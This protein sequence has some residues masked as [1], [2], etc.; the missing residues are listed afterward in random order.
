MCAGGIGRLEAQAREAAETQ[1]RAAQ[2]GQAAVRQQ[3]QHVQH[4]CQL[5]DA[6]AALERELA[7]A[8]RA[9][10]EGAAAAARAQRASDASEA[11]AAAAHEVALSAAAQAT[12]ALHVAHMAEGWRSDRT[13]NGSG[14]DVQ[15]LRREVGEGFAGV[16]ETIASLRAELSAMGEGQ[17][18]VEQEAAVR[19]RVM[20]A[21]ALDGGPI[22][23]RL[24]SLERLAAAEGRSAAAI[25]V[26]GTRLGVVEARSA[27][28]LNAGG[29]RLAI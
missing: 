6:Q 11:A 25:E 4:L 5:A 18:R 27:D 28:L 26:M 22:A 21:K 19:M 17:R 1:E 15:R 20:E 10:G 29:G 13:S 12:E 14:E 8:V 16:N 23:S 3:Q 2:D 24:A 9:Q 7:A